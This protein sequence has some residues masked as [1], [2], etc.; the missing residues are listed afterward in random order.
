[1]V[2]RPSC[3][4]KVVTVPTK[5]TL[6]LAPLAPCR[7]PR[8][9]QHQLHPPARILR[10]LSAPGRRFRRV[11]GLLQVD[12]MRCSW[13]Q[14]ATVNPYPRPSNRYPILDRSFITSL[15]CSRL[16]HRSR[17][18]NHRHQRHPRPRRTHTRTHST[19]MTIN[20][21]YTR[22]ASRESTSANARSRVLPRASPHS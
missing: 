11:K 7:E 13:T 21:P 15:R 20:S 9:A 18:H 6:A 3:T 19:C 2:L 17:S 16:G 10:T 1:V 8:P 14:S 4:V 12:S 22:S 5:T